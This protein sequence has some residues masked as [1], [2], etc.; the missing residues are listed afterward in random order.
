MKSIFLS[1][2]STI[3]LFTAFTSSLDAACVGKVDIGPAFVHVDILES[4]HTVKRMDMWA[5]RG[6]ASYTIWKGLYVKPT[7]LY[8]NGGAAKGGL[9]TAAF[10]VGHYT[11][12]NDMFAVTPLLGVTYSHLWTKI[13]LPLYMLENLNEKFK[14]WSPYLGLEICCKF[15][16]GWRLYGSFQYAW[17][18]SRTI[19][20][21]VGKFKSNC[22]GPTYSFLLE[23]DLSDTWSVNI[24]GAYNLSL[25]KEK[26]GLR[27]TGVKIGVVRWF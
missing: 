20:S 12:L 3:C 27:G 5:I 23:K 13:D 2:F 4:G 6:D 11:P 9:F 8:A 14:A 17:S 21:H 26:H 16:E 19:I 24:G 10:G 22:K 15:Y 7:L 25:S 18:R 1:L